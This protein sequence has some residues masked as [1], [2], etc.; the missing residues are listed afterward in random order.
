LSII[1]DL[2]I[3]KK[4][5]SIYSIILVA[6]LAVGTVVL[7]VFLSNR[8][9]GSGEPKDTYHS[10]TV[11]AMDTTLDV[12]IQS[13]GAAQ[14]RAD[15]DAVVK[16]ARAIE[17]H[18]SRF[19]TD[20][21]VSKINAD[22]GM[23]P[24][25][26]HPDT[27]FLVQTALDYARATN[28]AFDITVAP[29]SE[30][31]GFYNQKYRLPSSQEINNLLPLV[32]YT[33]VR[34][35]PA[36]GTVLLAD[37]G[38]QIDLGGIAKG[39]AVQQMYKLLKQRGVRHAL[40]NFG[41]AVGALGRRSDGKQWVVG[42]KHPRD[43]GG[44]LLGELRVSSSGDYE[45]YFIQDGKRYC[46]IFDPSTGYQPRRVISTTVVGPDS[47]AED[48]LSTALFVMG[49][50]KGLEFMKSRSKTEALI[51]GSAG[52]IYFTPKMKNKYVI[53]VSENI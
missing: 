30:L 28:G 31:W 45:R 1:S 42:I 24:V 22:A 39:Y 50:Q 25:S 26:V 38:M 2:L 14:A 52:N 44:Q 40:I 53:E 9:G 36:A 37:K 46:H 43:S 21:D 3:M 48:M 32:D 51:V 4:I 10:P 20:S 7:V 49:P 6:L 29:I 16:V 11:F 15:V 27:L 47:T 19:K 41:G 17:A 35:D 12:T 5:K 34:V 23:A 18:T 33:K 13:R 8:Q